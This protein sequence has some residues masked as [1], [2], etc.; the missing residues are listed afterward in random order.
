MISVCAR[1]GGYPFAGALRARQITRDGADL[2]FGETSGH[3]DAWM[4]AQPLVYQRVAAF[5]ARQVVCCAG[6][7]EPSCAGA[8]HR[9]A[10][11]EQNP[12]HFQATFAEIERNAAV[13][14]TGRL[15]LRVLNMFDGARFDCA[16]K[17]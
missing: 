5:A 4:P 7:V 14:E 13:L 8:M 9:K 16:S 15:D 3:D 12:V 17:L 1:H 6:L 2:K 11:G 10:C